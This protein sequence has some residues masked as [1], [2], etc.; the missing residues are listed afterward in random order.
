MPGA[1]SE[2]DDIFATRGMSADPHK[3][4]IP[5]LRSAPV[6][7]T[8]H[9]NCVL[10]EMQILSIK[11][12]LRRLAL[13]EGVEVGEELGEADGDGFG[14]VDFGVALGSQGCDGEGHGDAVV[15]A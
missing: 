15:G 2:I 13:A 4:Q 11:V 9:V 14:S 1:E 10:V 7:M 12:R 5:P 8:D 3:Q 6:G